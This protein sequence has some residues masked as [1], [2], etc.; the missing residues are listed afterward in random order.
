MSI[1]AGDA[2]PTSTHG[3][4]TFG[5]TTSPRA[6]IYLRVS[7]REQ[8]ERG[9]EAEGFSIPAQR[10]ACRRAAEALGAMAIEVFV[11]R[12]ESARSARRP[13]L[14]RMLRYIREHDVQYVVVHKLDRLARNLHDHVTIVAALDEV[15][16]DLISCSENIDNSPT[17]KL[18]RTIMAG[19]A[20]FYSDNLATEVVKG[21]RE[22]ARRGG[23]LGKAPLGYRNIRAYD[24]RG[25]EYRTVDLD[26]DRA[27]LI[28]W[29]FETYATGEWTVDRLLDELTKRG[30]TNTKTG[31]RPER[32][33]RHS[34]LH[35]LLTHP[36]Y[37]GIV[38][39]LGVEYPGKHPRLVSDE[40]WQR[41][42]E[43]LAAHG[44]GEKQRVHNHYLKGTVC[45][46]KKD[47]NGVVCGA[48]LIV[49]HAKSRGGLVYPY[50]V[51]LNRHQKRTACTFKAVLIPTVEE[52]IIEEYSRYELKP[53]ERDELETML[54]EELSSL[55]E[56]T[57]TERKGLL[58]KQKQ[59]VHEQEKLLQAH[60]AEAIPLDLLQREQA[61]I[62]KSLSHINQQL[63][64]SDHEYAL[65][66][67][68]LKAALD[69]ATNAQA[70]YIVA[71]DALR[72]RLNQALFVRIEVDED[73]DVTATLASPFDTLLNPE[74]RKLV[75]DKARSGKT[76]NENGAQEAPGAAKTR[77]RRPRRGRVGLK[78]PALVGAGG[79]EPP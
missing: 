58:K 45:C 25:R 26:P 35:K 18:L 59:L 23:T 30:L 40:I 68:N 24:E 8:A 70:T 33:L 39:Y 11:D 19:M 27:P 53:E 28:K 34:H 29:A 31:T 64:A 61:R 66:A 38:R 36:Y 60:Y 78:E 47:A 6:V 69:L 41:V 3:Q 17:G 16:V 4:N 74:T 65:I 46:G 75:S 71:S 42:Q 10:E 37:K 56:A 54:V 13:E 57:D 2:A 76:H 55:R 43:T 48:R 72:R 44:P 67:A 79:F 50:F 1:A 77:P 9:G 73:G 7:T 63:A 14:Q 12:G 22:K 49:S 20:Q 62:S 51:C 21:S 5:Q 52:K 15:G 32:P